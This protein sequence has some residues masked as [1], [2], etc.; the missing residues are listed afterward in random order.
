[1]C[2]KGKIGDISVMVNRDEVGGHKICRLDEKWNVL[3]YTKESYKSSSIPE[4]PKCFSEM[5]EIA[6]ILSSDFECV[7]V[8]LYEY[9]DKVY[10]GELTF[11]P[12]GGILFSYNQFGLDE[13]GKLFNR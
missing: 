5:V 10:F 8:D 13:I 12:A 7:R 9:K 4:K 2:V 1:M 3:P 6:K 11:S